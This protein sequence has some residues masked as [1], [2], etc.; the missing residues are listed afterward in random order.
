M[1]HVYC[2]HLALLLPRAERPSDLSLCHSPV[3]PVDATF[4]S[5]HVHSTKSQ[6]FVL[7]HFSP[8]SSRPI[9]S[10][11]RTIVSSYPLR[12]SRRS[13]CVGSTGTTSHS[14]YSIFP[15]GMGLGWAGGPPPF[16]GGKLESSPGLLGPLE[17]L[18]QIEEAVVIQDLH[19][20][21]RRRERTRSRFSRVYRTEVKKRPLD[22]ASG[23][24]FVE[25]GRAGRI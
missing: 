4:F 10:C 15:V 22:G 24:G 11:R 19:E 6:H 18:Q 16:L 25:G 23:F 13:L 2:I 12:T 1:P 17:T 9:S 3:A 14:T 21:L 8:H 20:D 7:N 5:R